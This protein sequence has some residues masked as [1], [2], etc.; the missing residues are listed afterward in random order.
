VFEVLQENDVIDSTQ[1]KDPKVIAAG[2]IG[3]LAIG[4]IAYNFTGQPGEALDEVQETEKRMYEIALRTLT[5]VQAGSNPA[6]IAD[7][8]DGKEVAEDG[9]GTPFEFRMTDGEAKSKSLVIISAGPD[10]AV[11]TG[12]DIRCDSM[13]RFQAGAGYDVYFQGDINISRASEK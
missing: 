5:A 10:R 11:K 9:W 3:V 8:N 7:L 12:D 1:L 2:A 6:S 4:L 13:I